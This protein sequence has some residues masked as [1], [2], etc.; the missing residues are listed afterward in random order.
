MPT[1]FLPPDPVDLEYDR[2]FLRL[3]VELPRL[4]VETRTFSILGVDLTVPDPFGTR[5]EFRRVETAVLLPLPD[6]PPSVSDIIDTVQDDYIDPAVD[7]VR[8]F[9]DDVR[10]DLQREIDDVSDRLDAVA[11]QIDRGLG[12]VI[13]SLQ[14]R[15]GELREDFDQTVAGLQDDVRAARRR[16]DRLVSDTVADLRSRVASVRESIDGAVAN[17]T[18]RLDAEVA[19]LDQAIDDR[20]EAVREEVLSVLPAEFISDPVKWSFSSA[21]GYFES[22]LG[23]GVLQ[24]LKATVDN[25]LEAALEPET[26]E[27][28]RERREND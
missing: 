18:N 14:R 4:E 12:S 22:E 11:G 19:A 23:N 25:V 27:R 24:S 13:D 20:V 8:D 10:R 3:A 21:I 15:V 9:A 1:T 5:L 6:D 2:P 28:L 17:V 7:R 16:V 26:K